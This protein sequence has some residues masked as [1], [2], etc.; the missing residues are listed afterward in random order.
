MTSEDKSSEGKITVQLKRYL[1]PNLPQARVPEA[2]ALQFG[3]SLTASMCTLAENSD[4]DAYKETRAKRANF[5]VKRTVQIKQEKLR[6]R[7]MQR[8][9]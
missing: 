4:Q 8:L 1:H 9:S 3:S 5:D 6:L 7:L 2:E